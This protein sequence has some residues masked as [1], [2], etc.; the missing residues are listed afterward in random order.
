MVFT[1]WISIANGDI[2]NTVNRLIKYKHIPASQE[3]YQ[4][5][6]YWV[7][8]TYTE[9]IESTGERV[10]R[11]IEELR[12]WPAY[13]LLGDPGSGKTESFKREAMACDGFYISARNF[14]TL[15]IP[16]SVHGKTIFI[17]GLD[18]SR[19]GEGDGRTPLDRIRMRLDELGRPLFRL[20]CREWD[21]LGDSDRNALAA[22]LS[23]GELSIIHLDQ[24]TQKQ[25]RDILAHHPSVLDPDEFLKIADER[26][27]ADILKNPQTLN[28]L[29]EAVKENK[30]PSTRHETFRLACEKLVAELNT[31]HKTASRGHRKDTVSLIHAAGGLCAIQLLADVSCFTDIGVTDRD[32]VALRDIGWLRDLP[33]TQVIKTRLFVGIGEGQFAPTHRSVAEYLAAQFLALMIEKGNITI[34][35][36]LALM[37]A[38]DGGVVAGLRGLNAWLSV[39]HPESRRRLIK[40]DPLG[41]I[42]YGDAKLF[43][44][45]DKLILLKALHS[46]AHDYSG[47]RWQDWSAK[48]FG[49]LATPDMV[50]SFKS[51]LA[52]PLQDEHN[53]A[54]LYCVLDAIRFGDP[55][56][57][58]KEEV[59]AIVLNA[60]LWPGIR[61]TALNAYV[62]LSLPDL[63]EVRNIAEGI[64]EGKIEDT[65]DELLGLSLQK[66]FPHTIKAEEVFSYLHKLKDDHLIGNYHTFWTW[67]LSEVAGDDDIPILMDILSTERGQFVEDKN[68]HHIKK[69]VGKLLCRAI[70]EHGE[71]I[72]DKR[73]YAWLGTAIDKYGC[74]RT[75]RDNS[76]SIKEWLEAHPE[77]YKGLLLTG[78]QKTDNYQLYINLSPRRYFYA[79]PPDDLG[80]WWLSLAEVEQYQEKADCLFCAA[81]NNFYENYA[82][83]GLSVEFFEKWVEERPRFKPVYR[84]STYQVI[85]DWRWEEAEYNRKY[86]EEQQKSQNKRIQFFR[87]HISSIKSGSAHP[88]VLHILASVYLGH[89]IE[90]DG[91][92]SRERLQ[93]YLNADIDLISAALEGLRA[94]VNR[95]DL[96][97]V[98]EILE[99]DAKGRMHYIRQ[100]CL[101]GLEE[102]HKSDP[103][104]VLNLS[105][106]VLERVITFQYTYLNDE[107]D[108]FKAC[109]SNRSDIV[110]KV[111][112]KY[113][114]ML[115]KAKKEHIRG[116]H[117][118][119]HNEEYALVARYSL[120]PLLN[121][122]P[123]RSSK[124]VTGV[125]DDLLKAALKQMNIDELKSI[126]DKKLTARSMDITQRVCWL[127]TGLIVD[128]FKY[129]P[130]MTMFLGKSNE[131]R[132]ILANFFGDRFDHAIIRDNMHERCLSYLIRLFAPICRPEWPRGEHWASPAIETSDFVRALV[133]QIGGIP[134][135]EASIEI[136]N[137]LQDAAL[138]SWHNALRH[139]LHVQQVS[140]RE[141]MFHRPSLRE[142]CE[143]LDNKGP[144]NAAD[145]AAITVECLNTLA[146]EIRN[147]NTDQ[148]KQFWNLDH[149]NRPIDPKPEEA[150]RDTLL[151]KLKDRLHKLGIETI[152]EAHYADDKRADIRV[153]YMTPNISMAIP[154]EIKRDSHRDLWNAISDQLIDLYTREPESKGRGIFLVLWFGGRNMPAPPIGKKPTTAAQLETLLITLVPAEKKELISV[155][156]IDC[157]QTEIK[158]NR[159][160]H[161]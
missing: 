77:R 43:S 61:R 55:L 32:I 39:Y 110:A 13:I 92:T 74:P 154:I 145:L 41:V 87:S 59:R 18:E 82:A 93:N 91:K 28:L 141:A 146:D 24:L 125:L 123:I 149:Y 54:F 124:K 131:R 126:I 20:S 65:D 1:C 127:A 45:D 144:A 12:E 35:R 129:E 89:F 30:W 71:T 63:S 40:V 60:A 7:A 72:T 122:F 157:A 51:I 4:E 160:G 88:K 94:S 159:S 113:I 53:Q 80:L 128:F 76:N 101:A 56:P 26:G 109:V 25:I 115:V 112:I 97:T 152:P 14:L 31:E 23:V 105:D 83:T 143:T 106:E 148:Y 142:V 130:Q 151:D 136:Q 42:L 96:P 2:L 111:L 15:S 57:Q 9:I 19:A 153:S 158:S 85:P 50:E 102:L 108:W 69:M 64:R 46:L 155:C 114:T 16:S 66:L 67:Q 17:D 22:L 48:P 10:S 37:T 70:K 21:W 78:L 84:R 8:R 38:P 5:M 134:S 100:A 68:D 135:T 6:T 119:A 132:Q 103:S 99:L 120:A 161:I 29:I 62:H 73:L 33:A 121:S 44:V 27:L 47:F 79:K 140:Q 95:S 116:V 52:A 36:V 107:S 118:L 147:G 156:V 150:C 104:Y 11:S 138:S 133:N 137:L 34:G 75:D 117:S 58:L 81:I 3:I 86:N 49:G 98:Y 90:A 139:T